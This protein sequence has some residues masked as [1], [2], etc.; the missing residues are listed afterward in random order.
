MVSDSTLP[1]LFSTHIAFLLAS[2][3][4]EPA[5]TVDMV[6]GGVCWSPGPSLSGVDGL[7]GIGR[8]S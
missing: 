2:T 3:Q 5:S 6:D 4:R 1:V 8:L 7:E